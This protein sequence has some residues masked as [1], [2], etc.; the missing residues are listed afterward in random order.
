[1]CLAT[2]TYEIESFRQRIYLYVNAIGVAYD[3]SIGC[4]DIN[5]G[6]S[7]A[8]NSDNSVAHSDFCIAYCGR[9]GNAT[10]EVCH[11]FL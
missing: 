10:G 8:V 11:V 4:I 9:S 7:R 2:A 3:C 5:L 1:M 6:R